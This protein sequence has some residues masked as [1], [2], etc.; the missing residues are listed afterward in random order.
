MTDSLYTEQGLNA[1]VREASDLGVELDDDVARAVA[2]SWHSGQS[3]AFYAFA[4]S[5]HFAR[6]DLLR[7]LSD[8][9]AQAYS[10]ASAADQLALDMFGTYC[11]NRDDES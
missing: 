1:A 9:I 3:S 4:S 5:G 7:E 8:H 11:L 6:E 10:Y 2:S